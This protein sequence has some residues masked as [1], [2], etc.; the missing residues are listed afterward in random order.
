MSESE[1]LGKVLKAHSR[2][3]LRKNAP[4]PFVVGLV[5]V[6]LLTIISEMQ[7]HMPKISSAYNI[8]MEQISAGMPHSL[9]RFLSYLNPLGIAFIPVLWLLTAIFNTGLKSYC[10]NTVREQRASYFDLLDGLLFFG[11]VILIRLISSVFIL[12]WS[13]LFIIP[14]L[15]A[16]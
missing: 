6:A 3:L 13:L 11:K 10:M 15:M 9:D 7:F 12:L 14:G 2:M 1:N 5:F 8:Y 4:K 16:F